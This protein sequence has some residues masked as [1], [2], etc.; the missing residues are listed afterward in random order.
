MPQNSRP[1]DSVLREELLLWFA[2][3]CERRLRE[4]GAGQRG[5]D[6]AEATEAD[7]RAG[8]RE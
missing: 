1:I 4:E 7:G 6:R 5:G 2:R 3:A 8:G